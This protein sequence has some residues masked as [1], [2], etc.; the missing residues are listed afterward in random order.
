MLY[1]LLI[2]IQSNVHRTRSL[3]R[4]LFFGVLHYSLLGDIPN[5]CN[6]S[7]VRKQDISTGACFTQSNFVIFGSR[8][9]INTIRAELHTS[10]IK[11]SRCA[12][13]NQTA[14]VICKS[15]HARVIMKQ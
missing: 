13:I 4:I 1:Y 12:I 3:N 2:Q 7:L 5:L 14:V 15:W 9:E 6:G 11:F 10:D 8:C